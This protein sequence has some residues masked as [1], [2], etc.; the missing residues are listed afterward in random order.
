MQC[1]TR[2]IYWTWQH[3]ALLTMRHTNGGC[4]DANDMQLRRRMQ[5]LEPRVRAKLEPMNRQLR[6]VGRRMQKMETST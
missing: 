2:R 3:P 4:I 5:E 6:R 1:K